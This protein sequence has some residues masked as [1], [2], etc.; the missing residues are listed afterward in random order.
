M[1]ISQN[2]KLVHIMNTGIMNF[3][4]KWGRYPIRNSEYGTKCKIIILKKLFFA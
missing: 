4:E 1:N 2:E 3:I